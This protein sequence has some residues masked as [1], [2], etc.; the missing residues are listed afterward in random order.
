MNI[1]IPNFDFPL[2]NSDTSTSSISMAFLY[3]W[4]GRR[5]EN[6]TSIFLGNDR[7]IAIARFT[8]F[9]FFFNVGKLPLL[10]PVSSFWSMIWNASRNSFNRHHFPVWFKN[11]NEFRYQQS[12][13]HRFHSCKELIHLL[14]KGWGFVPEKIYPDRCVQSGPSYRS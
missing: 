9:P 14:R 8:L 2:F 7:Y 10:Y 3:L 4:N 13:G 5:G 6:L 12:L 1:P 11:L